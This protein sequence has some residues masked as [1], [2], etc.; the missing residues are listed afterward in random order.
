VDAVLDP[1]TALRDRLT[2]DIYVPPAGVTG[3]GKLEAAYQLAL[4]AEAARRKIG[5][6]AREKQIT[7]DL[8][9]HMA[10]QAREK[11]V[12]SEQ[13]YEQVQA[14]EAAMDD[15]IQVDFFEPDTYRDRK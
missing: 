8:P 11:G 2:T 15:V 3:L 13:E 4:A 12:I 10:E 1:Q 9:A 7:K 6:A 5:K 14:A